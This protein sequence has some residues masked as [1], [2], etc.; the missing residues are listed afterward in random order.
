MK[1][2]K[3]LFF[4][5]LAYIIAKNLVLSEEKSS[6]KIAENLLVNDEKKEPV[7]DTPFKAMTWTTLQLLKSWDNK[8]YYALVGSDINTNPY[9]G[10]TFINQSLPILCIKKSDL[11]K[12]DF[13]VSHK[14]PGGADRATWSGGYIA[15]TKPIQGL[16]IESLA[17]A[18]SICEETLGMGYRM[19]Q[20]H[21]GESANAGWDFWGE[22]LPEHNFTLFD[23]FWVYIADQ[24]A[25]PWSNK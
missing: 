24:S 17:M 8:N 15:S 23:R 3:L 9:Q 5:V 6:V 22:I 13:V 20:F 10:D 16:K 18:N 2:I 7:N 25:N 14:T 12:P 1:I 19:A 21:D 4:V 11:S